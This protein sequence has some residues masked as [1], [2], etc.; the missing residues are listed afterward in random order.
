M[1]FFFLFGLVFELPHIVRADLGFWMCEWLW[2]KRCMY[3]SID[4]YVGFFLERMRVYC[5]WL[6]LRTKFWL[7]TSSNLDKKWDWVFLRIFFH[8]MFSRTESISNIKNGL[9]FC[10]AIHLSFLKRNKIWEKSYLTKNTK[11]LGWLLKV[12]TSFQR[13]CHQFLLF[14]F[15]PSQDKSQK[16]LIES[17]QKHDFFSVIYIRICQSRLWFNM[18]IM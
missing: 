10:K 18:V 8:L 4:Q 7:G 2:M 15:N 17:G 13:Y 5:C 3:F 9:I 1:L 11:R 14:N 12:S 16:I 6:I